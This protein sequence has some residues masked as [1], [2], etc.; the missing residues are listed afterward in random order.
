VR[1]N[2]NN[3]QAVLEELTSLGIRISVNDFGTSY[4]SLNYLSQFPITSVKLTR[5]FIERVGSD[6]SSE[7]IV[8]SLLELA[9]RLGL[10]VVANGVERDEQEA[11]LRDAGC[12]MLQGYK[13][14]RPLE[15]D[16]VAPW[17]SSREA[18]ATSRRAV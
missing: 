9:S 10:T 15:S 5:Q 7:A 17:L 3:V 8:R 12:G 16:R 18:P 1:S 11:F 2:P 13:Y 4:A 14:L 6:R